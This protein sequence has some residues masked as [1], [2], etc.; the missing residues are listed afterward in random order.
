MK[1]F[2]TGA[3]GF[4]GTHLAKRL[5]NTEHEMRCLVRETSICDCLNDLGATCIVGDVV[6]KD[7]VREAMQGCE[8]VVNLA[9]IYSFWE[10]NPQVFTDVNIDGTRNVLECALALKAAKVVH[11]STSLVYG[12]P[13][14]CPFTEES[15]VGPERFS[16][17]AKTK[18]RGD[19]IAW[20]MYE[21][22]GLPLVVVYPGGVLGEGDDKASGEYIQNIATGKSFAAV[23]QDT[24]IT[25]VHV[26]DV[27]EV[28][29]RAL[30][31]PNN[32]GE[33][34]LVGKY[35]LT[36]SQ[37][38]NLIHEVSGTPLPRLHL[39]D[40]VVMANA[41]ILTGLSR[42][43]HQPPMLGMSTDQ[44]RTMKEGLLFDGSKVEQELGITYT[45]IETAFEE[46]LAS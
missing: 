12:K 14:D 3:T 42:I 37:F 44:M 41:A 2:V 13:A 21:Q 19:L 28:I 36:F 45:P 15:P 31:K 26:K 4:I 40:S 33:K 10:A 34:Y 29:V 46:V 27:A 30:E 43:T 8:W 6:D 9:N 1:I 39:S 18:Y 7:S 24:A 25:W 16:K 32:I 5:A 35:P 11:V 23:F 22:K 17:Y 20:R 38:N